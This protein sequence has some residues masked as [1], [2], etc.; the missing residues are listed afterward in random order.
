MLRSVS[1]APEPGLKKLW[2]HKF[3][4][5]ALVAEEKEIDY[6]MEWTPQGSDYFDCV[7]AVEKLQRLQAKEKEQYLNNLEE[8]LQ[9]E[10]IAVNSLNCANWQSSGAG[11]TRAGAG[12]TRAGAGQT[13]AD[14]G[15]ARAGRKCWPDQE[16]GE[17]VDREN[18]VL[19]LCWARHTA[20]YLQLRITQVQ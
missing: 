5:A 8:K 11:Q 13:R 3:K 16:T 15:Q 1:Q 14:A 12:Q 2:R 19:F 18:A 9:V 10:R 6:E 7:A 4:S 20:A 17:Y